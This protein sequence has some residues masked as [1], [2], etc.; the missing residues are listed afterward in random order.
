MNDKVI[1]AIIQTLKTYS[2]KLIHNEDDWIFSIA[3]NFFN[4]GECF[5]F[6]AKI[7][8][9]DLRVENFRN[10]YYSFMFEDNKLSESILEYIKEDGSENEYQRQQHLAE[11]LIE[12]L[13]VCSWIDNRTEIYVE[14]YD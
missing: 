1:E 10:T 13:L 7:V 3:I 9:C 14:E 5:D 6:G 4:D 11:C 2:D 8:V 12:S